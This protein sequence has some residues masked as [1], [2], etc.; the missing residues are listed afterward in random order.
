MQLGV[1]SKTTNK[2]FNPGPARFSPSSDH[3]LCFWKSSIILACAKSHVTFF[4][5]PSTSSS[6]STLPP[7]LTTSVLGFL[8]SSKWD[9]NSSTLSRTSPTSLTEESEIFGQKQWLRTRTVVPERPLKFLLI[10]FSNRGYAFSRSS[11]ATSSYSS[12]LHSFSPLRIINILNHNLTLSQH[13]FPEPQLQQLQP[14][15][16]LIRPEPFILDKPSR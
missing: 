15:N 9:L 16:L 10:L 1:L 14:P 6:S 11:L 8:S 5:T 2:K 4:L 3:S 13:P 7:S 12:P